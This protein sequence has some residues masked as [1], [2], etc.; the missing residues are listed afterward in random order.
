MEIRY[1]HFFSFSLSFPFFSSEHNT[2][3][4]PRFRPHLQNNHNELRPHFQHCPSIHD[5]T[6]PLPGSES[7]VLGPPRPLQDQPI[8]VPSAL[9]THATSPEQESLKNQNHQARQ[10][11]PSAFCCRHLSP[12][13][14][15]QQSCCQDP[16]RYSQNRTIEKNL[17][18][19]LSG[20]RYCLWPTLFRRP[21]TTR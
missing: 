1:R 3:Q 14:Q 13:K 8:Q 11:D 9:C 15:H 21:P 7:P 19:L 20:F 4:R 12:S 17:P 6:V 10:L 2:E 18:Q 16:P 5:R